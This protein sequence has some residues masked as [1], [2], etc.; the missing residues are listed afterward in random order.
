MSGGH[1]TGHGPPADFHW[2]RPLPQTADHPRQESRKYRAPQRLE[3]GV[4][5]PGVQRSTH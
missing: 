4:P 2:L 1:I 3:I 5:P